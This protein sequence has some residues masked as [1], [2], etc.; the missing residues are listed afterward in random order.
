MNDELISNLEYHSLPLQAW[1]C[2]LRQTPVL[3]KRDARISYSP[4]P[5][6]H[7]RRRSAGR[8]THVLPGFAWRDNVSDLLDSTGEAGIRMWAVFYMETYSTLIPGNDQIPPIPDWLDEYER[9]FIG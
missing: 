8:G 4:R 7:K 2:G 5:K 3:S 6:H 9:E 1:W